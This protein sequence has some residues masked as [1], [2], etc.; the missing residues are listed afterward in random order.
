MFA[1]VKERLGYQITIHL[2]GQLVEDIRVVS[3]VILSLAHIHL[4]EKFR[5]ISEPYH[6]Y[7]MTTLYCNISSVSLHSIYCSIKF[8]SSQAFSYSYLRGSEST[9]AR[10]LTC[11]TTKGDIIAKICEFCL[12]RGAHNWARENGTANVFLLSSDVTGCKGMR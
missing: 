6:V 9:Y 4:W 7:M 12:K 8:T 5:L 11:I 10:T 1:K 3:C 2:Y